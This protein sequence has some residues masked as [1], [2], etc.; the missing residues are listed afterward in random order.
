MPGS[1]SE[2]I[3]RLA[4]VSPRMLLETGRQPTAEE[5]ARRSAIR[6]TA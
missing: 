6:S 4:R 2:T 5:L 3:N 1:L